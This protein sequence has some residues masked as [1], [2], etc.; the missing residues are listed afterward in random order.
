M[1]VKTHTSLDLDALKRGYEEWDIDG[2]LE[3]Y[4]DDVELTQVD[5]DNPPSSPRVRHGKEVFK[6]MFDHCAAA[7]VTVTV[8]NLVADENRA[9]ATITCEFPGGRKVVANS[10]LEIEDGRIVR[11]RDVQAGDPKQ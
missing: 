11:E 4:A 3:L 9:A 5:R 2:L 8:E 1:T 10:I 6:G 7:G